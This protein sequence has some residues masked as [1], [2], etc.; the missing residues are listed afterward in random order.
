MQHADID[1]NV[2]NPP[3]QSSIAIFGAGAVGLSACFMAR[4]CSPSHLILIDVSSEK[5]SRLPPNLGTTHVINSSTLSPSS[6]EQSTSPIVS[7]LL[8]ITD[9]LGVDYVIDAVG[10]PQILQDGHKAMAKCGTLV[11]LGGIMQPAGIQINDHLVKGG[12]YRGTHQGDSVPKLVSIVDPSLVTN[13]HT[14]LWTCH[15]AK[16]LD[17]LAD[18]ADS[19]TCQSFVFFSSFY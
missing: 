11:T 3:I 10:L 9:G 18:V 4:L 19:M 6:G 13:Y 12:T 15:H 7:K 2:L 14:L 5:L 17:T 16:T 8:D 1:R